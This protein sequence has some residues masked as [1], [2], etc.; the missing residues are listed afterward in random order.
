MREP[1]SHRNGRTLIRTAAGH[2]ELRFNRFYQA[3]S[4]C[5]VLLLS[6]LYSASVSAQA[7]EQAVYA[8]QT[9]AAKNSVLLDVARAGQRL[10]A[11]GDRGHILYSDNDGQIWL[12]AKVPT[13]QMLTAVY[14]V[15][16]KYGWAVGHDALILST[17]DGGE[18]WA[19]QYDDVEQESPLLDI[20]FQ[21]RKT[22]YAV[23][24]YGM[25]LVTHDGGQDWQRIDELL[26]NEDGYHLN[27]ISAV[28]DAGLFI[29]GEMGVMFRSADWGESWEALAGPYQGSL[30]GVLAAQPP[31]HLVVYGLRGH[32]YRSTDFGETWLQTQVSTDNGLLQFGL[33]GASQLRNGDLVIVGHGGTVLRSSDGGASFTAT[34]RTDRA[35][36]AG[37]AADEHDGL[38]LVGQNGV[39]HTDA[40]GN[41]K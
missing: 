19:R 34:N 20:W 33:A 36:L 13:Q 37:V 27:A 21:D 22:G 4:L 26:D 3:L 5:S 31:E 1:L 16:D 9:P 2:S 11:V 8:I 29:V 28:A 25:L 32:I 30:F 10:V 7:T 14:F 12:Q 15:D 40:Q 6:S 17:T 35:S 38:I 24:A 41:D 39:Y 23:G 18:T